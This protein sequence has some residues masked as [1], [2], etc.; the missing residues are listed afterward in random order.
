MKFASAPRNDPE[1]MSNILLIHFL[2]LS[3]NKDGHLLS[4]LHLPGRKLTVIR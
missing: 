3:G 1:R 4:C 2:N